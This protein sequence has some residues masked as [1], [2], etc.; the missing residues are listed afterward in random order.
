GEY[1]PSLQTWS[2]LSRTLLASLGLG[3][4]LATASHY[5][6]VVE[7]PL[8]ALGLHARALAAQQAALALT[9]LAGLAVYPPL[10]FL[11]GGVKPAELKAVIRRGK[12]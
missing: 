4:L 8:R 7:A 9:C 1:G 3:V 10:L 11:F 6:A 5:R 2:R 12:A